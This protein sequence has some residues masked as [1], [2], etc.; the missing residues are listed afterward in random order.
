ML[1]HISSTSTSMVMT[2]TPPTRPLKMFHLE[3]LE[4]S[5]LS[6]PTIKESG[7]YSGKADEIER[8]LG[9]G[10]GPGLVIPY[11][12]D[13][14]NCYAR[15]KL[16]NG[17]GDG[18]R[19]RSPKGSQNRLYLPP[20]LDRTVL[21]DPG[22]PIY[23]TEGEKKALKACQ[24]GL[25]C[26]ALGGVWSWR[27][28]VVDGPTEP[29]PDL[30]RVV[31]GNRM[32]YVVFDSDVATNPE[33]QRAEVELAKEL[34]R[35]GA[36]VLAIRLPAEANGQKVGLDD[37]LMHYSMEAFHALEH[38]PLAQP[39]KPIGEDIG[40]FLA[41]TYE[42]AVPLVEGI[43]FS[44]GSGW[45]G[46]EEKL[47]KTLYALEEALC[48]A[49]GL[50]VCGKF[51]VRTPCRVLFIEEEDSPQRVQ[52]RL[53]ALLRGHGLDPDDSQV[54][55]ALSQNFRLAVWEKFSLDEEAAVARL[56]TTLASFRPQVVYCD[57]LRKVTLRDLNKA[58]LASGLLKTLDELRREYGAVYRLVHHYRKSQTFRSGRGSQEISGSYVLGAWAE[59]S[60][61]FEPVGRKQGLVKVEVQTKDGP[62]Q[63]PFRLVIE[64]EGPSHDPTLIRL[65]AEEL[66]T[67]A[68]TEQLKEQVFQAV[69]TLPKT[70]PISGKPGVTIKAIT[71]ALNRRSDKPIR[72]ALKTLEAEGRVQAV[73]TAAKQADLY[74]VCT[75]SLAS[76]L[77]MP[78]VD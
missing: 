64:S 54:L 47:G 10:A 50:S 41:R 68:K 57:A 55:K 73:G 70:A 13:D 6:L 23:V 60:L 35:R 24:E 58:D 46:G 67:G 63:P 21:T 77:G 17:G 22:T 48:L 39:L 19:Y 78:S 26:M 43:L 8:L 53:R 38:L 65:R 3:E 33:I 45:I 16:D 42:P 12:T 1:E 15:V 56:E 49:L 51:E 7:C 29:I 2:Q 52:R 5:G 61:F 9:Y 40:V 25:P 14:T 31:W 71:V 4:A 66:E 75:G 28:K 69:A 36:T 37:F 18:K 62:P 20:N 30:D 11:F 59:N 32:V 72:E 74:E 44:D 27:T 34:A 76:P